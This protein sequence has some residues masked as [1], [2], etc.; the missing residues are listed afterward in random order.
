MKQ[1]VI[2]AVVMLLI[3]GICL[4]VSPI[5]RALI[6]AFCAIVS[7]YEMGKCYKALGRKTQTA[8]IMA[9]VVVHTILC[10][11]G[12][13]T[14]ALIGAFLAALYFILM[15][16]ICVK[17]Y[18]QTSEYSLAILC[19]PVVLYAVVIRIMQQEDWLAIC[20]VAALSTWFCDSFA[21]FGGKRFGK[22][23]LSPEVSPKKTWEGSL[24]GAASSIVAGIIAWLFIQSEGTYPFWLCAIVGLIASTMGQFGDLAAS[25]FKREAGLKDYSNL[26]PGHGGM[27]DRADSL[28]FSIPTTWVCMELYKLLTA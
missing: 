28:L 1:R 23:K 24:C 12:A 17:S 2:S 21:L 20:A 11:V 27:M 13:E 4:F 9:Y 6:V 26:I 18:R 8:P 15:F 14:W 25:L 3:L 5:T 22:H 10:L 7:V 16:S 19:Y